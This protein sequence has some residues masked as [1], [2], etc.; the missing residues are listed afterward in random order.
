[1]IAGD[2]GCYSMGAMPPF[3]AVDMLISMGASI[4]MA[5][6][7][8]R[9]GG[10]EQ[11]IAV[12]GDSTFFHSGLAPLAAAVYNRANITVFVLDNRITAMTG[13]QEH[14]GTGITLQGEEGREIDIAG[15]ARALGVTFVEEVNAWDVDALNTL[16]RRA[17][18]HEDG[19]AVVVVR[20]AC[21]YTPY[22][23]LQPKMQVDP[24]KCV[25]CGM[26]FQVGCPAIIKSDEIYETSGKRKATIDPF[27]C[28][29]CTVCMQVCPVQAI[30]AEA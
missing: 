22:F 30:K 24:D 3:E 13:Q 26:C 16:M 4:G 25:T 11:A 18:R 27:L 29:G 28:T 23:H 15:V 19:P 17:M 9:A 6:G 20:G 2:I 5:H 12:I 1:V 7:F 21:V 10:Q 8:N 14:P